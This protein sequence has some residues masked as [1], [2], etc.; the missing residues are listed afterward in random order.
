MKFA[1]LFAFLILSA[2][3]ISSEVFVVGPRSISFQEDLQLYLINTVKS[4]DDLEIT[5]VGSKTGENLY[6]EEEE[7]TVKMD[8]DQKQVNIS[9]SIF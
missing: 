5:L 1:E 3:F 8:F 6:L 7:E 4:N 2:D 9:V